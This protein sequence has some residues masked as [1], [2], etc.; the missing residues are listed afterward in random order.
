MRSEIEIWE[1]VRDNVKEMMWHEDEHDLTL[2]CPGLCSVIIC[3]GTKHLLSKEERIFLQKEMEKE[4]E[5]RELTSMYLWPRFEYKPRL[6]FVNNK[7]KK[8]S[9]NGMDK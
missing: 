4:M 5:K 2:P 3:L 9:E 1:V 7:I 6:E 8:L